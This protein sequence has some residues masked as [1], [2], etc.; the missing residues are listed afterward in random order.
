[1]KVC[2]TVCTIGKLLG[3]PPLLKY[4]SLEIKKC[5]F[6][7]EEKLETDDL[8]SGKSGQAVNLRHG[9]LRGNFMSI[10]NH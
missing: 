4:F 8:K 6:S 10:N 5:H 7:P 1:M 2:K 9:F 3:R